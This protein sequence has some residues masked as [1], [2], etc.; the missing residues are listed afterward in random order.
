MHKNVARTNKQNHSTSGWPNKSVRHRF[1]GRLPTAWLAALHKQ[2]TF[3]Y[4]RHTRLA[5]CQS[6]RMM[7]VIIEL[8]LWTKASHG[9]ES[10]FGVRR[11]SNDNCQQMENC[12]R[13]TMSTPIAFF[14]SDIPRR[15]SWMRVMIWL[16][17]KRI[18]SARSTEL[19]KHVDGLVR[20]ANTYILVYSF[21]YILLWISHV[22]RAKCVAV[23]RVHEQ[24]HFLWVAPSIPRIP[25][26]AVGWT[27]SQPQQWRTQDV[28]R[29][30][31]GWWWYF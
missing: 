29:V 17:I 28:L 4:V 6:Q 15:W 22:T 19:H 26:R 11:T 21:I 14:N 16:N 30:V 8:Y 3:K 23:L 20:Y 7:C 1:K 18:A 31:W 5:F 24:K 10:S 27:F 9:Q 13:R 12:A 25:S 2:R